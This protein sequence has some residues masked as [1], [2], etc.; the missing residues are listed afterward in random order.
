MHFT[1][2]DIKTRSFTLVIAALEVVS[3]PEMA[4]LGVISN[5]W[6]YYLHYF[7]QLAIFSYVDY[8]CYTAHMSI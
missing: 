4:I 1:T 8:Y 3:V 6:D 7:C 5:I 2:N